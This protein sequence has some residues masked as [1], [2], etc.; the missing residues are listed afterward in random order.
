[1]KV[2]V[3]GAT[4]FVG[5]HVC[6]AMR[7]HDDEVV[8]GVRSGPAPH[9]TD[10]VTL[11]VT[12]ARS[13]KDALDRHR[14][15]GVIHLAAL[16]IAGD[17]WERLEETVRTN[18]VGAGNLLAAVSEI[19]PSARVV[20]VG[21]AHQYG[22]AGSDRALQET[23]PMRPASPYGVSKAAQE[24]LGMAWAARGLSVVATR[25]FNHTGPGAPRSTAVGSF[26][27]QLAEIE[28]GV[29]PPVLRVGDLSRERDFV[30]VRDVVSA[31]RTLL[32]EGISGEAYNVASGRPCSVSE[33]LSLAVEASTL[34]VD[35]LTVETSHV[36][37]GGDP[38]RL[39][40]DPGKVQALGWTAAIPFQRS[41]ADTLDSHRR[42]ATR[43]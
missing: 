19:V 37:G 8:A 21:T 39:V 27:A 43:S 16:S 4:G 2:L 22:P 33:A 20:L 17:S 5:G 34:T 42:V 9:G 10:G 29:A 14:P 7:E 25:S 3:T 38:A 23:D 28:A 30:D 41:V 31:Y 15:D 18:V 11:D 26:C 1:M 40:G 24:L 35:D 36:A 32:H 13:V 12:D 6:R